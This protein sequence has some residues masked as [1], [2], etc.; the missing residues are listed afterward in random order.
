[1][2]RFANPIFLYLLALIPLFVVAY[3]FMR[4]RMMKNLRRF[5]DPELMSFLMPDVS[6]VRR[7]VKFSLL[8]L[9][10]ALIIFMLARPQFG[11]RNEE[12]KRSGIEAIVA[13]DVSNSMLCED[14][15]P[16]R[17]QKAKMIVSKLVDQLDEDRMGLIAFAGDAITLL[18]LTQDGVSAKMFL[19]QLSPQTVSV[20]GTNMSESIQKAMA[21]FSSSESKNVGRALIF[22]TD[23]ED[24]EPGA[25]EI[26]REASKM[27]VKIFV[28]SVGT[29]QGGPI[30]MGNGKYKT[31]L[32]G[33]TVM[34]HLNE[35]AGQSLAKAGNG[36][37]MHVDQTD[38]AQAMLEAEISKMQKEDFVSSMYS[39]Y[40]EQFVAVAILL[41]I[42]LI[43]EICVMEK[44]NPF[45][46][47]IKIRSLRANQ[48]LMLLFAFLFSLFTPTESVAQNA[49]ENIRIGNYNYRDA[50]FQKAETYYSKSLDKDKTLEAYFNLANSQLLQGRDSDAY[51]TYMKAMEVPTTNKLKRSQLFHNMGNVMYASG[52]AHMKIQDGNA[53]QLFGTAVENYKSALRMNPDDNETR[54]NLALAQYM[55]KKTQNDPKQNNQ[56]N[57]NKDNKDQNKDKDQ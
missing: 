27:G 48:G 40:D 50:Q 19:E 21:G 14:V 28:L 30:P 46:N 44:K 25:D 45:F 10:L 7:H 52:L 6:P 43:I 42:V 24:N 31:D 9:A 3:V 37:Y 4:R 34:T 11:T 2:F 5:G 17:L 15:A 22:I 57:Q 1:M 35:S 55:F 8:M 20:Q 26:A 54:Y 16:N 47:R 41:L 18:P 56:N 12:Y 38:V 33:N 32:S 29:A 23:A 49:K 36:V 53:N 51:A 39:E 13:V